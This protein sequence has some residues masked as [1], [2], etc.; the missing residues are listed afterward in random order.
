MW[1]LRAIRTGSLLVPIVPRRAGY[2]LCTLLGWL[3]YLINPRA[4]RSVLQNLEQIEP[5]RLRLSRHRQALRVFSTVVTNYYDLVRLHTLD[6]AQFAADFEMLGEENIAAALS[7]R[8]GVIVIAAHVGNFNVVASYPAAAGIPAAVIA[9]RVEPPELYRYVTR[10]RSSL[11]IEVISPG[12]ESIRPIL[13][14]LR[15]NHIVIV[16]CDRDVAGNGIEVDF[17]GAPARLPFGPVVLA[18][19]TG[20]SLLPV[21]TLRMNDRRSLIIVEP[22]LELR[23][24]GDWNADLRTNMEQVAQSLEGM[25]KRDPGQ[26]SVLQ[27][28]WNPN[29]KPEMPAEPKTYRRRAAKLEHRLVASVQQSRARRRLPRYHP[30]APPSSTADSD[31]PER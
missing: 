15:D 25:I 30:V 21:S 13:R 11:G 1:K 5:R 6:R 4:R 22:P 24:S 3:A 20:A 29:R 8:S 19:R 2:W 16:A 31:S 10:L 7:S 12:S 28:I 26:W 23:R 18:M 17:F 14:H 9:E 27:P